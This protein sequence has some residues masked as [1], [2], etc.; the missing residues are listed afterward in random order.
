MRV[1]PNYAM[2]FLGKK[3]AV[4]TPSGDTFEKTSQKEEARL[5]EQKKAISPA[6]RA[7][8]STV[9]PWAER[10]QDDAVTANIIF[11]RRMQNVFRD[12]CAFEDRSAYNF[13]DDDKR[14][15]SLK[16]CTKSEHSLIEKILGNEYKTE[17]EARAD[18]QDAI[19]GRIVLETG[20]QKECD[21][22]CKK[23]IEAIEA[24]KLEVKEITHYYS[25]ESEK[26]VSNKMFKNLQ[27]TI[28]REYGKGSCRFTETEKLSGYNGLHIIFKID[29]DFDA[30]LQIMGPKVEALKDV[31]DVFY[32]LRHS[33]NVDKKYYGIRDKYK[34]LDDKAK[35]RLDAYSREAYVAQRQKELGVYQG[36]ESN[37]FVLLDP[38]YRLP[39]VFDFNYIASL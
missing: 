22:I 3:K 39:K 14:L 38:K 28:I 32:K 5:R 23:L 8:V 6:Q 25:D 10:L 27:S 31:E 20:T 17:A 15:G 36:G 4:A 11:A 35:R 29:D 1:T 16:L 26:Y 33:K 19:R 24:H 13:P 12:V 9:K 34:H 30:E 18:I 21:G 2:P 37:K 7:N